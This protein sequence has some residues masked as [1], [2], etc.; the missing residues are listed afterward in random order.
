MRIN[1][2][3]GSSGLRKKRRQTNSSPNP[4]SSSVSFQEY[5]LYYES[6]ERVTDRRLAMNRWNYSVSVAVVLAIGAVI[7]W[8][9]SRE[10]FAFVGV[11]G[12]LVLSIMAALLCTFW[13]KQID[14]FKALNGAKFSI[15]NSMAPDVVFDG[16]DGPSVAQSYRPFER[17]WDMLSASQAVQKV[18]RGRLRGAL[19]LSSSGAEYFIPKALR[20]LFLGIALTTVILA[21]LSWSS[22]TKSI[23]PFSTQPSVSPTP[24]PT[25]TPAPAPVPG[26]VPPT[27]T[28]PTTQPSPT[29]T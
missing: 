24:T 3:E 25:P 28:A 6:A 18:P 20:I 16:P 10:S 5:K 19:V 1:W 27:T 2:A 13:V 12:V 7:T 15:L 4:P 23:S 29:T 8:S 26:S 21:G 22:I 17:E 11:C 9:A 14:D